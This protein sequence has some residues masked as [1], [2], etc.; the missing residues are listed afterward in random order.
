VT[1]SVFW[2]NFDLVPG[3]SFRIGDGPFAGRDFFIETVTRDGPV[4]RIQAVEW[5]S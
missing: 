5:W 3:A 4:A 2:E 1:F